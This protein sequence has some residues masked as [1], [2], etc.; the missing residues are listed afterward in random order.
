[1]ESTPAPLPYSAAKAALINYAKNVSRLVGT[2]QVRVNCVAPGNILF[3]GGSWER[4]IEQ[5]HDEVMNY[6][7]TEVP[8]GRFGTPEEIADLVV[9][10]SSDRASFITGAC[11]IADGGQTR[12]I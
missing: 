1:V 10:L 5:R 12:G 7:R 4:H 8:L 6:I 3:P 11:V 9:F 2:N